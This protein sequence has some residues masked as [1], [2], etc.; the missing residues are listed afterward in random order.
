MGGLDDYSYSEAY[1]S[2]IYTLQ[3]KWETEYWVRREE[4][5]GSFKMSYGAD[6]LSTATCVQKFLNLQMM[7]IFLFLS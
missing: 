6:H 1:M 4:L 3:E 7:T 2:C 5:G